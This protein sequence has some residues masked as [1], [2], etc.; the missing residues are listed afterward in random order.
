L[1]SVGSSVNVIGGQLSATAIVPT[2]DPF[3]N[4]QFYKLLRAY[5]NSLSY[6]SIGDPKWF[7]LLFSGL[8]LSFLSATGRRLCFLAF[9][10]GVVSAPSHLVNAL[11]QVDD[12]VTLLVSGLLVSVLPLA[13][14]PPRVDNCDTLLFSRLIVSVLSRGRPLASG[15]LT[16]LLS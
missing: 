5:F 10:R 14:V 9:Q 13:S 11:A 6:I 2:E 15:L 16:L 1:E 8:I 7:T 3:D 4:I 12:S